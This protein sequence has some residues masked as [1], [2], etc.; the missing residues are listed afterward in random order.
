MLFGLLCAW[1]ALT[2]IV[3]FASLSDSQWTFH[4]VAVS[5]V[6]ALATSGSILML[7]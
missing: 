6:I 1:V 7:P 2:A 5:V 4:L 3:L